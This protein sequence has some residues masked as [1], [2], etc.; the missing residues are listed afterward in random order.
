M[1]QNDELI[2]HSHD[3]CATAKEEKR[4]KH[5]KTRE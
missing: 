4:K 2:S 1:K 5:T 3:C